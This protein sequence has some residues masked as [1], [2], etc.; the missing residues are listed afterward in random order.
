M[1]GLMTVGVVW[2]VIVKYPRATVAFWG[3]HVPYILIDFNEGGVILQRHTSVILCHSI[4]N[5]T[6]KLV[7]LYI[8]KHQGYVEQ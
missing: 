5:I 4:E 2:Y 1:H 7:G 6:H 3:P 8:D